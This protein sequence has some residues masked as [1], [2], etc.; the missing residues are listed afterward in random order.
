MDVRQLEA[1]LAVA[2]TGSFTSAADRLHTV[3]SNVSEHVR[4]LEA[5]LGVQLL[6]RGR[7][8]TVPTEF[9]VRVIER[10]RADPQ[11][12]RSAAQ[13]PFDAAGA[14]DRA[15]DARRRRN[16]ES[17]PRAD[18]RRGDAPQSRPACRCGSPRARPND[19]RAKSP[20]RQL[21]SA[22]VT[23]PVSDPRLHVEH[24]RDE[25][26]VA[27]VPTELLTRRPRADRAGRPRAGDTDPPARRQPAARRGRDRGARGARRAASPDRGRRC[28][29][30]RRPR[31]RGR[32]RVD[33]ARDRGRVAITS[34]SG[35]C[36]SRA[37]RRVGSRSSPHGV[38]SS[39]SPTRPC[40]TRCAAS[41]AT[42]ACPTP[43]ARPPNR[44]PDRNPRNKKTSQQLC[45][46][47]APGPD[48]S[49][50]CCVGKLRI[51][52]V[53]GVKRVPMTVRS[54]S[55][56]MT[57]SR[58]MPGMLGT[59][60]QADA[61]A[62]RPHEIG[63]DRGLVLESPWRTPAKKPSAD[64]SDG[65]RST[66]R[67]SVP[68]PTGGAGSVHQRGCMLGP[69]AAMWSSSSL[70][71]SGCPCDSASCTTVPCASRG[72]RN[73]SFHSGSDT[74]M[75]TGWKPAPRTRTSASARLGTLN[76]R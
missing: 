7:R 38:C 63:R 41:C 57:S 6:V 58:S 60:L 70:R 28:A 44:S 8:G 48:M 64:G 37:C 40:T 11:R 31:R 54:A 14:R 18:G 17:P 49:R 71:V 15:R 1:L 32:R 72:M 46:K 59:R 51:Y 53:A 66:T 35:S 42:N 5:E 21:A 19:S 12:D 29:S 10:A 45:A 68:W 50:N 55:R 33:P 27:L 30:H 69:F 61:R 25:A 43:T 76:V 74:S 34:E 22:V 62:A 65:V 52:E 67:R 4:Q 36:A 39:H 47:T 16:R 75:L 26:L 3:Q 2:E 23:E 9:G 13:R 24:L 20:E 73:A 56:P